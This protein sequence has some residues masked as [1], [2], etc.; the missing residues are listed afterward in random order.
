MIENEE[1]LLGKPRCWARFL[2]YGN[3]V[4]DKEK[5]PDG[6]YMVVVFCGDLDYYIT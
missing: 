6:L 2:L 5:N 4:Q 3:L 1:Q